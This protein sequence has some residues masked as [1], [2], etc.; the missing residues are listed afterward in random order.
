[1]KRTC[2][3]ISLAS[4]ASLAVVGGTATA[5]ASSPASHATASAGIVSIPVHHRLKPRGKLRIPI[6]C[7]VACEVNTTFTLVL[8]GPNV[9]PR[10]LPGTLDPAS[11]QDLVITLNRPAK[12]S[13]RDNFRAAKLRV[14][15]RATDPATGVVAHA[16]KVLR[17]KHP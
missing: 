17:F 2:M 10:S 4:L 14:K 15:A 12:Q 13:L 16:R 3:I 11:P 7:T 8:P 9:G 1:M 5:S 6:R